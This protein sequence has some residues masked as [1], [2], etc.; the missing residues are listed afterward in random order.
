[1]SELVDVQPPY[2]GG[3]EVRRGGQFLEL[4]PGQTVEGF[5]LG[6]VQVPDKDGKPID[7]WQ[8]LVGSSPEPF[9]LPSHY[10]LNEKL[11]EV[12][13]ETG[14]GSY[15]WIAFLGKKKVPKVPTPMAFYKVV[16]YGKEGPKIAPPEEEEVPF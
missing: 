8:L 4:Q 13:G 1:M 3:K 5:L 11:Q 10:D 6:T 15:V 2:E 7:R 12:W 14:Q 9:I 16:N